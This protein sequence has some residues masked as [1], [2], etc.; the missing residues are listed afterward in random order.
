MKLTKSNIDAF[1][2]TGKP[3]ASGGW[4]RDVRWD[5]APPGFGIRIYPPQNGRSKKSFVLSYRIHGRKRLKVIGRYGILT[6]Q[7]ARNKARQYLASIIDNEDPFQTEH[8]PT[9][10]EFAPI[11]IDRHAKPQKKTWERDQN[12]INKHLKPRFGT[13]RL[14]AITRGDIHKFHTD[15]GEKT[16]V[17]ANRLLAQLSIMFNKAIAWGYLP[18]KTPNPTEYVEPFKERSRDR[19]ITPEEMPELAQAINA[20]ENLYVRSVL[21]LYIFTGMRRNELLRSQWEWIDWHR[22]ELRLP[23]TKSGEI[24]YVPLNALALTLLEALPRQHGNPY[25]FPSPR[26]DDS[27][28]VNIDKPWRRIRKR[29]GLPDI[30]IHDLRRTVG[31]WLAESGV[32]LQ[33]IGDV[34]RHAETRTT[35]KAYAR[36]SDR[37]GKRAMQQYANELKTII[38]DMID[39]TPDEGS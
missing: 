3:T 38:G 22:E 1:E 30:R 13:Y 23:D 14:H 15:I 24:Q 35:E 6:V 32:S 29:A 31:S 33:V 18:E 21:W 37:P 25:I 11:Y 2:Y 8:I 5:D 10:A 27:H 20:E 26:N 9:F 36:L 39:V 16:P 7:Q 17:L 28:L 34:L 19:Y 12:R 4:T